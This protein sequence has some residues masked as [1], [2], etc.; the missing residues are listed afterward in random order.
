MF[1]AQFAEHLAL[2]FV[3]VCV[4]LKEDL[5]LVFGKEY[6]QHRSSLYL[7]RLKL[8]NEV[9]GAFP[10]FISENKNKKLRHSTITDDG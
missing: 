9:Q 7:F 3:F 2:V 5:A 6:L 1:F 4:F 8:F 10:Q